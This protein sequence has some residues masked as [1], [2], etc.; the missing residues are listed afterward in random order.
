MQIAVNLPNNSIA[1]KVLWL[2]EHFK[3]DGVEIIELDDRDEEIINN[4][5]EGMQEIKLIEKNQL[6]A[7]PVNE[8]LNEL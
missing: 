3:G 6:K 1:K 7:K 2:L 8:F 4:F 5:R